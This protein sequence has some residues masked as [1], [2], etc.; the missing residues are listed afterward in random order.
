MVT[1]S[2]WLRRNLSPLL[3]LLAKSVLLAPK[4]QEVRCGFALL[5]SDSAVP[6]R[7]RA[8]ALPV[9]SSLAANFAEPVDRVRIL[10]HTSTA[11][12]TAIEPQSDD[13][14][15][16]DAHYILNQQ[17]V[18]HTG[19]PQEPSRSG[20]LTSSTTTLQPSAFCTIVTETALP[21]FFAYLLTLN[22]HHPTTTV[23]VLADEE[24]ERRTKLMDFFPKLSIKVNFV[25]G[26]DLLL[27][28]S[29]ADAAPS[30]QFQFAAP[31]RRPKLFQSRMA[32]FEH[33]LSNRNH[34]EDRRLLN[35]EQFQK[36]VKPVLDRR[37]GR[38][39]ARNR[40]SVADVDHAAPSSVVSLIQDE[41]DWHS[42]RSVEEKREKISP[43]V[44][45]ELNLWWNNKMKII[46]YALK[47]EAERM[48]L[49]LVPE[50]ILAADTDSPRRTGR[51]PP[52]DVL[53][54]DCDT[55]FLKPFE[56][57][58]KERE[59]AEEHQEAAVLGRTTSSATTLEETNQDQSSKSNEEPRVDHPDRP[60]FCILPSTTHL[61]KRFQIPPS[62]PG[63]VMFEGTP[64]WVFGDD[65]GQRMLD[66]WEKENTR[67]A[68]NLVDHY[69]TDLRALRRVEW[70]YNSVDQPSTTSTPAQAHLLGV[71]V[72]EDAAAN[73]AN[74]NARS[75]PS[76]AR[77]PVARLPT[78]STSIF[79]V[80]H[81]YAEFG[82]SLNQ[83]GE[84]KFS[85]KKTSAGANHEVEFDDAARSPFLVEEAVQKMSERTTEATTASSTS[86][87]FY[88]G[89]DQEVGETEM[90]NPPRRRL[91]IFLPPAARNDASPPSITAINDDRIKPLGLERNIPDEAQLMHVHIQNLNYNTAHVVAYL[92]T[93][94]HTAERFREIACLLAVLRHASAIGVLYH[95]GLF[96]QMMN[97][98]EPS[99]SSTQEESE[100]NVLFPADVALDS[101]FRDE[102][103]QK[104][105]TQM[106]TCLG[107]RTSDYYIKNGTDSLYNR[108][109][110]IEASPTRAT[111][112]AHQLQE[113]IRTFIA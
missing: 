56:I 53:Y 25:S 66:F 102:P 27:P 83:K 111:I 34:T 65:K 12:A 35:F 54:T 92:L 45:K 61:D 87:D 107:S 75:T 9:A 19:G 108:N 48:R 37:D 82:M 91:G 42:G 97:Q 78:H 71:K 31:K 74:A 11:T 18:A 62:A 69:M 86:T 68:E 47:K 28:A 113:V 99:S 70:R 73:L 29:T 38:M 103:D 40:G 90:P 23:Y 109:A 96:L 46:R 16:A 17:T 1:S 22:I 14:H 13:P 84:L 95:H 26:D 60:S 81:L 105:A 39:A 4:E 30:E 110:P 6:A 98:V 55:W 89:T 36:Y 51:V 76:Y 49:H 80:R 104:T 112:T 57:I 88:A 21:D 3:T 106:D 100:M 50:Q 20:I 7:P 94:L 77:P 67:L 72:N 24:S 85:P 64:V 15:R 79:A 41:I 101:F 52:P 10:R 59:D 44:H 43:R 8:A 58:F 93:V 5:S 32:V 63:G 2:S 33:W